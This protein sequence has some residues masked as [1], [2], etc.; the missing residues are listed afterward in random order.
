MSNSI[1]VKN[2]VE[3]LESKTQASMSRKVSSKKSLSFLQKSIFTRLQELTYGSLKLVDG[4]I[5]KQFTGTQMPELVAD[6]EILN[7]Q[8][9]WYIAL[10]GSLGAGEAYI[11]G[12]WK[13][14]DLTK[15]IQLFAINQSVMDSVEGGLAR[16]TT[17]LKKMFHW[18][19][20]NTRDGSKKNIVA[21]YDLG[22]PFFSE[23]LD[24][25][26]MY[27]SGIFYKPTDSMETASYNKLDR[28]CQRL[29]LTEDDHLVE[30]GTGWG[31]FAIFAAKNYGCRVTTTTISEE[32]FAFAENRIKQEG[33]QDKITLLKKDYR[34]LEGKFDKLVSI[35]MIEAVGHHFFDTFFNKCSEL[36]KPNGEMLLQAITIADQR[37]ESAKKEIDYIKRYIFPGSCIPSVDSISRSVTKSTDM[38]VLNSEDI[39]VHYAI[40]LQKWRERFFENIESI[41][42]QGF[43]DAFIRMWE[44]YLCYCEGGFRERVISDVQM[45]LVKPVARVPMDIEP[46]SHSVTSSLSSPAR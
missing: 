10:G 9:Y 23:F 11:N 4:E 13:S 21:H 32:Q 39:G 19:N 1:S 17:P 15:V 34:E 12:Y 22:N 2:L 37:F 14:N 29:R 16:V 5:E 44:F 41:K 31:G 46:L 24:P 6:I 35:E 18:L 43:S 3:Q 27:S 30:I 45:H 25:T 28:I 20:K 8:F 26:M 36:L 38:R 33:L 7:P 42:A 40:T